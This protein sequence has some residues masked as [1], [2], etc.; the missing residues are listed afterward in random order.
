MNIQKHFEN[1]KEKALLKPDGYLFEESFKYTNMK[2]VFELD[3]DLVRK[4]SSELSSHE[5]LKQEGIQLKVA[6]PAVTDFAPVDYFSSL[7]QEFSE[8]VLEINVDKNT[9]IE[10]PVVLNFSTEA[11]HCNAINVVVKIGEASS[12]QI[13]VQMKGSMESLSVPR[14]QILT[15]KNAAVEFIQLQE[16]D[17]G[18]YSFS[19]TSIHLAEGA[20][21]KSLSVSLGGKVSRHHLEVLHKGVGSS[22]NVKGIYLSG[23]GQQ[24]DHYTN[25]DH[26][27]GG[28]NSN[29][30]Y[31][32]I[33]GTKSRAVFNGK[34]MIRAGAMKASSE[35]LNNN[36]VLDSSAEIDTKPQLEI[37][38]DDVKATH[39]STVGQL[40]K[41]ELF[42]LQSR[43]ISK[44]NAIRL[45]SLGFVL[46]L[47]SEVSDSGIQKLLNDKL[48]AKLRV[49]NE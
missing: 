28:C 13:F 38:N 11:G 7:N 10:K 12:V 14:V 8:E 23:T 43:A 33:L 49:I 36:L 42:Y 3:I 17:L 44:E 18:A 26:V 46:A 48:D 5:S 1:F 15:E 24:M 4:S 47:I 9:K 37:Y 40:N 22:S 6:K 41:E 39:G 34:V 30:H 21:L 20:S 2:Q 25:I 19:N 27:V 45:L 16:D 31:K 32:G 29:Q 35:Q